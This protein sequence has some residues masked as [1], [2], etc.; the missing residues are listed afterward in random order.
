ML[1]RLKR[2][3]SEQ[4]GQD[5]VEYALLL[6]MVALAAVAATHQL[7]NSIGS[8]YSGMASSV[9]SDAQSG[10]GAGTAAGAAG[11]ESSFFA[12]SSTPPEDF[13]LLVAR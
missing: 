11:T 6:L 10:A 9:T 7:A 12:A 2:L 4:R 13:G 1:R 8:T 3:W 5:L